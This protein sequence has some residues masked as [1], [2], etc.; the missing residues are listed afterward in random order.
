MTAP[1][2]SWNVGFYPGMEPGQHRSGIAESFEA[3]RAGFE[4]DWALLLPTLSVAAFE[5]C[6]RNRAFYTWK[7]RMWAAGCRM[8]TQETSGRSRCFFGAEIDLTGA[9]DHLYA[10]HM[11][12]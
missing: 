4:A 3:A 8:P 11:V 5:E 7:D 2:W 12:A 6:R 9:S 10:A 1:Q